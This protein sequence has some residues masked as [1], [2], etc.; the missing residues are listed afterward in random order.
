MRPTFPDTNSIGDD[1]RIATILGIL[2][3]RILHISQPDRDGQCHA[4]FQNAVIF[5]IE[6]HVGIPKLDSNPSA[7]VLDKVSL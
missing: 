6:D 7:N 4:V 5:G 2:R 1:H 3:V